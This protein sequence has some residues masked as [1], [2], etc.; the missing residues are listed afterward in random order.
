MAGDPLP[1]DLQREVALI[2]NAIWEQGPEAVAER[3]A[4]IEAEWAVRKFPH[5]EELEQQEDGRFEVRHVPDTPPSAQYTPLDPDTALDAVISETSVA[6]KLVWDEERSVHRIAHD[7]PF[8]KET[9]TFVI[10]RLELLLAAAISTSRNGITEHAYE[11]I[12]IYAVLADPHQDISLTAT[13]LQDAWVSL[14]HN[15]S[16]PDPAYP[17]DP[18]HLNLR[19]ALREAVEEICDNSVIATERC[20]KLAKM[21]NIPIT[22]EMRESATGLAEAAAEFTDEEAHAVLEA[23]AEGIETDPHPPKSK[24]ARF[25]NYVA[26]IAKHAKET[27]DRAQGSVTYFAKLEKFVTKV[28]VWIKWLLE[29]WPF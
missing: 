9:I 7:P 14:D 12:L 1:W 29:N 19:D 26:T 22:R 25:F 2:P 20:K 3:I 4:E 16:D 8:N 27:L 5:A 13:T 28:T 10:N 17:S 15:L 6:P 21:P 11:A 18:Q 23:D 24:V